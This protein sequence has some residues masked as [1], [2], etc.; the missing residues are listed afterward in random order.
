MQIS[1]GSQEA[2]NAGRL[3]K[4]AVAT[5]V[6]NGVGQDPLSLARTLKAIVQPAGTLLEML[7]AA[8][9]NWVIASPGDVK[10]ED[11]ANSTR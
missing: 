11:V 8:V 4:E 5:L 1:S 3:T 10:L 9:S 6:T 2:L 7:N